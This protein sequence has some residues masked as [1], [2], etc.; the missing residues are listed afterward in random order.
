MIISRTL[1]VC[2]RILT[3]TP[4]KRILVSIE[5]KN[6]ELQ[7]EIFKGLGWNRTQALVKLDKGLKQIGADAYTEDSGM[8]SEHLIALSAISI[9]KCDVGRILEI[10]TFDGVTAQLLGYLFPS[11]EINTI[12]LPSEKIQQ[13][14]EYSYAFNNSKFISERNERIRQ[15]ANVKLVEKNSLELT[16]L[17][18]QFDLI[19]IDGDHSFPTVAVDI[20]NAIRM[21]RDGGYLLCDDVY[22]DSRS[23]VYGQ[24]SVAT[25]NVLEAFKAAHIIDYTLIQKRLKLKVNSTGIAKKFVAVVSLAA[26]SSGTIR[27]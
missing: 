24:D 9:S 10:G 2:L 21:L 17:N 23:T 22:L 16:L 8:Y 6:G 12:D 11:S 1:R 15:S 18:Q 20:T 3:H 27:E 25:W 19:W 13:N 14:L 4:F 5:N 26:K 7:S